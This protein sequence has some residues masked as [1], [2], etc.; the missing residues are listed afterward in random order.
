MLPLTIEM[1]KAARKS[2][3][4]SARATKRQNFKAAMKISNQARALRAIRRQKVKAALFA[5]SAAVKQSLDLLPDDKG[6]I[7]KSKFV[8]SDSETDWCGVVDI[9]SGN[10]STADEAFGPGVQFYLSTPEH[11]IPKTH[12]D[13]EVST[14]EKAR[15]NESKLSNEFSD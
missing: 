10:Q 1:T 14:A 6:F 2:S 13:D 9:S 5:R 8:G 7:T 11:A 4:Q 15:K 3:N 12:Q